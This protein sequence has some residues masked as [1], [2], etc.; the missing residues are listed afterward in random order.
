MNPAATLV[1]VISLATV[2]I[3]LVECACPLPGRPRRPSPWERNRQFLFTTRKRPGGGNE[4]GD[5]SQGVVAGNGEA[6]Y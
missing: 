2:A 5:L 1:T 3:F 6:T 4:T